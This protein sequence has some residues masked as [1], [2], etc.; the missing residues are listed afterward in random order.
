MIWV[1]KKHRRQGVAKGLIE[2]L[3]RHCELKVEDVAHMIPF[4]EDAVHLWKALKL[5]T[6]YVV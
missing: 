1:L 6:I 5:S 3:A 2:A 4:R